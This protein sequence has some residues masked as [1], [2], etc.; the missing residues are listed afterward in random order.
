MFR[1]NLT[2]RIRNRAYHTR[3]ALVSAR[4]STTSPSESVSPTPRLCIMNQQ[5]SLRRLI[6]SSLVESAPVARRAS[7][8]GNIVERAGQERI[9]SLVIVKNCRG[10]KWKRAENWFIQS[11]FKDQQAVH[12]LYHSGG[13]L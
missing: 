8:P 7:R 12:N 9:D 4:E 1:K 2:N 13:Q 11:L 3:S 6:V 10:R 5:Y